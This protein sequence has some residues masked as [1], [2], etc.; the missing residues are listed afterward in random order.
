MTHN[1]CGEVGIPTTDGTI[2]LSLPTDKM[3]D[4]EHY[5]GISIIK[6]A[7]DKMHGAE[8]SL[9]DSTI[10]YAAMTG[11]DIGNDAE[12]EEAAIEF[13]AKVGIW[14]GNKAMYECMMA[15]LC[16]DIGDAERGKRNAALKAKAAKAARPKMITQK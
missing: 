4:L 12:C 16:P 9:E 13:R 8:T 10:I 11:R 7:F 6:V 14:A 1:I 3:I 2:T 5:F 15:N